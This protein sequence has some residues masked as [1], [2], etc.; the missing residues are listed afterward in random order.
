MIRNKLAHWDRATTRVR[1]VDGR[2]I[3]NRQDTP[4]GREAVE[5]ARA[6]GVEPE[7]HRKQI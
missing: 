4:P 3:E 7:P 1:T 2:L 5:I 6:V